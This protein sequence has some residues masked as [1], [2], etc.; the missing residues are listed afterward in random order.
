M[1]NANGFGS[2]ETLHAF[3]DKDGIVCIPAGTG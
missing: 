3:S 1:N 2:C